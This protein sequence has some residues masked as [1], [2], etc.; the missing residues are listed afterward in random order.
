MRNWTSE[1]AYPSPERGGWRAKRAGW[2]LLS[3][4]QQPVAPPPPPARPPPPPRP[5][6]GGGGRRRGGR[7]V[8]FALNDA[9]TRAPPA[10]FGGTLPAKRGGIKLHPCALSVLP[11]A[12]TGFDATSVNAITHGALPLFTQ[13]WMV[14]RCTSTSPAFRC[15]LPTSSSMSISPEIT[16][17]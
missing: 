9:T 5:G 16:T 8:G 6:G 7:W 11:P 2:G 10:A 3:M 13:L 12:V 1:S 15:T 17:A 14:P 4:T